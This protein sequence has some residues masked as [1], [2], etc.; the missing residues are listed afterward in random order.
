MHRRNLRD[1]QCSFEFEERPSNVDQQHRSAACHDRLPP[2]RR[3]QSRELS[4]ILPNRQGAVARSTEARVGPGVRAAAIVAPLVLK[5]L[6]RGVLADALDE[7]ARRA[8]LQSDGRAVHV[9][10]R[11]VPA[12]AG[13]GSA[14][15][16]AQSKRG[17][18]KG[19][20]ALHAARLRSCAK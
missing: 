12:V 20:F 18:Q 7:A 17:R 3:S 13:N 10:P 6:W 11:P 4:S 8:V 15:P 2:A 1:D 19:P 16:C 5:F 14:G 9:D